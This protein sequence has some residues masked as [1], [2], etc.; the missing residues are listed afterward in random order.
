MTHCASIQ[1]EQSHADK[2]SF[3]HMVGSTQH[4][5]EVK[6]TSQHRAVIREEEANVPTVHC[7]GL[8]CCAA[9]WLRFESAADTNQECD[10]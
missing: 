2:E 8:G 5:A 6:V 1:M 3:D 10:T 9:L 4:L 7:Q